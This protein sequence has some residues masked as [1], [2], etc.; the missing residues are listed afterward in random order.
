[1]ATRQ[2][3]RRSRVSRPRGNLL[4]QTATVNPNSVTGESTLSTDI[5]EYVP[6]TLLSR[7]TVTRIVGAWAARP[8]VED[9]TVAMVS[10]IYVLP[11][12]AFTAG[13]FLEPETD[14][15]SFMWTDMIYIRGS[16]LSGSVNNQYVQHPIDIRVKRKIRSM[17][18]ILVFTSENTLGAQAERAFYLR[19]LLQLP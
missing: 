12:E 13:A 2:R 14:E 17:E 10:G 9:S 1:M 16:N 3:V 6:A 5:L 18:N 7:A 4:W 8:L 11:H 19:I 15:A